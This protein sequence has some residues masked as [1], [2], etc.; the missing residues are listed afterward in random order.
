MPECFIITIE[1]FC[2]ISYICHSCHS[3]LSNIIVIMVVIGYCYDVI[4]SRVLVIMM[5]IVIKAVD[6]QQGEAD[7]WE[8]LQFLQGLV[9]PSTPVHKFNI[10]KQSRSYPRC[11]PSGCPRGPPLHWIQRYGPGSCCS[12]FNLKMDF[13]RWFKPSEGDQV[14]LFKDGLCEMIQT[15]TQWEGPSISI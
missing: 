7:R 10:R 4:I 15:W 9:R 12:E 1:I 2:H 11:S 3:F 14:F 5:S 6:L 8:Q 13:V